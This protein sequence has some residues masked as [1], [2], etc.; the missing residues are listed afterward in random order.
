MEDLAN[1]DLVGRSERLD[2]KILLLAVFH[3]SPFRA[4]NQFVLLF[5]GL[6]IFLNLHGIVEMPDNIVE[7]LRLILKGKH[8]NFLGFNLVFNQL[9]NRV[10]RRIIFDRLVLRIDEPFKR[11]LPISLRLAQI[12]ASL[13]LIHGFQ[14]LCKTFHR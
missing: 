7:L 10:I 3:K 1:G 13:V 11:L 14:S 9:L 2:S 12:L 5:V 6:Q 8:P 4:Q